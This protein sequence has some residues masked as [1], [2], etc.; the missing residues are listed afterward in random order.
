MAFLA[1]FGP[2]RHKGKL[3]TL[4][5]FDDGLVIVGLSGQRIGRG[6]LPSLGSLIGRTLR[7]RKVDAA[8]ATLGPDSTGSDFAASVEKA[9]VI[10]L[11]RVTK[12][13][14]ATRARRARLAVFT[15]SATP[16][17]FTRYAY[18][19]TTD[20]VEPERLRTV[21]GPL[22]GER[23]LVGAPDPTAAGTPQ[24]DRTG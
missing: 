11:D 1:T 21:L 7:Q 17:Q 5:V 14:L 22:L 18:D 15:P 4:Y 2:L 24:G 20:A 23:L 16:D 12:V 6:L 3:R 10:P 9:P 13:E 8:G 19:C